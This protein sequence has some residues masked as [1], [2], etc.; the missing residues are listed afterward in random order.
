MV[1]G[2]ILPVLS[3]P[4]PDQLELLLLLFPH[5]SEHNAKAECLGGVLQQSA[6]SMLLESGLPITFWPEAVLNANFV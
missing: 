6:K 1:V 3:G 2:N 4:I 5:T